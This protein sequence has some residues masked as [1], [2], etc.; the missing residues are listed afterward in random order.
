MS[1]ELLAWQRGFHLC[2]QDFLLHQQKLLAGEETGSGSEERLPGSQPLVLWSI[3]AGPGGWKL[4]RRRG[5]VG[6]GM[7][8]RVKQTWP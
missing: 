6:K 3:R 7:D 8:L 5:S 4:A 1:A 2:E